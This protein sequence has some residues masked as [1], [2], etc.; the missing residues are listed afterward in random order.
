MKANFSEVV[1]NNIKGMKKLKLESG[2][3]FDVA[4]DVKEEFDA[5]I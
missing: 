1:C 5:R 3:A 4:D 2:V